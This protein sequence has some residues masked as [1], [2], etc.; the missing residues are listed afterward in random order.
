MLTVLSYPHGKLRTSENTAQR[1]ILP[2]GFELCPRPC[3][4]SI[5]SLGHETDGGQKARSYGGKEGFNWVKTRRRIG[6]L[7]TKLDLKIPHTGIDMQGIS[8]FNRGHYI[9][10]APL[11]TGAQNEE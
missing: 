4:R 6:P 8:A 5:G 10:W 3:Q 1:T 2:R 7:G 9:S 11:K